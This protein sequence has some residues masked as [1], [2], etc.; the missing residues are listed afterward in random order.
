MERTRSADFGEQIYQRW[1]TV[2]SLFRGLQIAWVSVASVVLGMLMFGTAPQVQDLFL[3]V[4]YNL[5]SSVGYWLMF[6]LVVI[7]A[8]GLP[9]YISS[10]WILWRFAQGPGSES[11]PPFEPVQ[12]WVR[13]FLPPLLTV[14]CFGAVLLGEIMALGNAPT[15]VSASSPA[16]PARLEGNSQSSG[17][18]VF[19]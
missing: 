17:P 9:V 13:Q 5:L 3:E 2:R 8:W 19:G 16:P 11:R 15:V 1:S 12:V 4:K 18:R 6:Y 14:A 7:V 10:R